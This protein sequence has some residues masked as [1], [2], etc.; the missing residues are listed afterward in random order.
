MSRFLLTLLVLLRFAACPA[1]AA[2]PAEYYVSPT[3]TAGGTGSSSNPW[4]LQT[5]LHHPAVVQPGDTIW[6]RG[7]T[8]HGNFFCE[9]N[10]TAIAPIY[11]RQF[12]AER[13][14][15]DGAA[16]GAATLEVAGASYTW[17]WGFEIT[18]SGSQISIT[19]HPPAPNA[20]RHWR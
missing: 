17:F 3:G 1:E 15:I 11:V 12:P 16:S 20:H 9:L 10:G 14:I 7:G 4:D 8:Y 13:V 2:P 18:S 19:F 6:L 5:A